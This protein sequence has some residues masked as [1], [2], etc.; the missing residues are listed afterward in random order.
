MDRYSDANSCLVFLIELACVFI[1]YKEAFQTLPT[2]GQRPVYIEARRPKTL[3]P[4]ACPPPKSNCFD[5]TQMA[6]LK[7]GNRWNAGSQP[8]RMLWVGEMVS[9]WLLSFM[10]WN[11]R[12]VLFAVFGNVNHTS[13]SSNSII[14]RRTLSA[15]LLE[16][17]D[18]RT[19]NLR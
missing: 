7:F 6:T 3:R 12:S 15:K 14:D 19:V 11:G 9:C 17:S 4:F 1:N 18:R 2:Y 13:A 8:I 16:S 10:R 5:W